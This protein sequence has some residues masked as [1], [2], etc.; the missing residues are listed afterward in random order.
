MSALCDV[1]PDNEMLDKQG[2]HIGLQMQGKHICLPLQSIVQ[3]FKTMT[4][5]E[6][7]RNVKQDHWQPFNGKLWQRNYYEHIIRNEDELNRIREYIIN[8]PAQWEFDQEN[9]VVKDRKQETPWQ[10]Q[11]EHIGS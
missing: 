2:K 9:P 4:T 7:I 11:G 8:N 5:N 6:Y 10:K 1:C 3:W